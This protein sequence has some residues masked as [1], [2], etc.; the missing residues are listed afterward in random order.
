MIDSY[1]SKIAFLF[2]AYVVISGGI[3]FKSLSC[4]LQKL[5]EHNIYIQHFIGFLL[6]FMFIMLE[7][8]W[9]FNKELNDSKPTDWSNG[10]SLHSLSFSLII[11]I[12]F[13]LSSKMILVNNIIFILLLLFLYIINTQRNYWNNRKLVNMNTIDIMRY[14]E[15]I[16]IFISIILFIYAIIDYYNYQKKQYNSKFSLITFILGNPK[17]NF[18]K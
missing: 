12:F 1:I 17:C 18:E 6:I 14:I 7:G 15:I 3:L 9:D 10:N 16:I 13:I 8:G 11:Y 4:Q 2:V 5:I